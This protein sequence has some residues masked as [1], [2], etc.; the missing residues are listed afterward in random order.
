MYHASLLNEGFDR[1]HEGFHVGDQVSGPVLIENRQ[2]LLVSA[3]TQRLAYIQDIPNGLRHTSR[4]DEVISEAVPR[5]A[6]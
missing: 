5:T 3:I 1:P 6:V 4:S 2:G